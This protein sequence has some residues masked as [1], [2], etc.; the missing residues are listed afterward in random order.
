MTSHR[1]PAWLIGSL[2]LALVLVISGCTGNGRYTDLSTEETSALLRE[3]ID[4]L[5]ELDSFRMEVIQG[6]TPY[7][8]YFQLGPTDLQF[9]TA[10]TRA[11]GAFIAPDQLYA[12]A[13]I[14]VRGVL[15]NIGL[16][17]NSVSQWLKPLAGNWVEYIYAPGFDPRGMMQEGDGFRYAIDNLQN[18]QFLGYV[19][20]NGQEVLHMRGTASTEVV[21]SLL[22]G[23]LVI[24][25]P[26]ATVDVFV[27]PEEMLP[28]ELLLTLPDTATAET[29]NT[30]W[31]IEIFDVNTAV[32]IDLPTGIQSIPPPQPDSTNW[33]GTLLWLAGVS[34]LAGAVITPGIFRNKGY[35]ATTGLLVGAAAGAVGSLLLLLPVWVLL[36]SRIEKPKHSAAHTAGSFAAELV[37]VNPWV[38]IGFIAIPVFVGSLD[39]TVVS[40]FLP[41]LVAQLGL[42]FDTGLDDASWIVTGYLLAYTISMTFTG[43]L[44]DLFGRK[45]VYII[46]LLTFIFGSVWVA[47]AQGYPSELLYQIYRQFGQRPDM[48]YIQLQMIIAGR[49]ISALGAGALVPVSLALVGDIFPPAKRARP[50]GFVAAMDTL[51]WVLGPVYGGIF[52]QIMPWQGLF[53]MNVPLTFL[54]LFSVLY[55]LRRVPM[56]RAEGTFDTLGTILIVLA[57][58]AMSIGLGSNVDAAG[59]NVRIEDL[60]PLPEYALPMLVL[61]G[62]SLLLFIVVESRSSDPLINLG[63]FKRRNLAAASVANLLIGYCLFIGLV[64]VPILVNVRQ[65]SVAT[66]GQA[67]L[68]V[69]AL[70]STLTLP[71]AAAAVPGGWLA[72]R[73]GVRTTTLIGLG[74]SMVG[75][76]L[77]WQT[78]T[79]EI[80]DL[81]LG[82]QMA[83]IG[84]G[85]GLTFSPISTAIIN[86][87]YDAERGVAGAIVLIL[88]LIGMTISISTLSSVMFY[89]VN[90]LATASANAL[91]SF[92]PAALMVAYTDAAV[93]VLGEMGLIGAVLSAI[94]IIPVLFIHQHISAPE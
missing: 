77:V 25:E 56:H 43:R 29:E 1:N 31:Q 17:A 46:S 12:S 4:N 9:V 49:V 8:F 85:I 44:S 69:G 30:Y 16:F 32:E 52:M 71:M 59:G 66:L 40:A 94:A 23:L 62:I 92:D 26:I 51:G 73:I 78:W 61:A 89:R 19:V 21:N 87:A 93:Q 54:A 27:D 41:E 48:A 67:A 45:R 64:S 80:S 13:R 63:M 5:R 82:L 35:R 34:G 74:M 6:G 39:M 83:L 3:A 22:F 11:D 33:A 24:L 70:L 47:V 42:P 79:L 90:A 14:N 38:V 86:S 55:A 72:D 84:T 57:L 18:P 15:I 58:A 20:R 75:F 88:R 36:P 7:R 10:M 28:T 76:V 81:A 2:L 91:G 60:K 53:W 37:G 68:Q 50:L 65:E